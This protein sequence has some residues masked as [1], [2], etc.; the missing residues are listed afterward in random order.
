MSGPSF[1]MARDR[2]LENPGLLL[3]APYHHEITF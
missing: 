1:Y 3:S 2:E